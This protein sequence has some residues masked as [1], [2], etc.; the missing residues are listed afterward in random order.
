MSDLTLV[1][2]CHREAPSAWFSLDGVDS[3]NNP[4]PHPYRI[5]EPRLPPRPDP[6]PL[7]NVLRVIEDSRKILS[8]PE[9]WD[10]EGGARITEETWNRATEYLRRHAQALYSRQGVRI[11]APR[12]LPDPSGGIDLHWK[13]EKRELLVNIPAP[14]A[15]PASF[16]GDAFGTNSIKGILDTAA[17]DLGI[18]TWLVATD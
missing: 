16:Y 5:T 13:T 7:S 18:F 3:W 1:S 6:N 12:I 15:E 11:P 14:I 4:K 10:D 8:L 2:R 9:D 17:L